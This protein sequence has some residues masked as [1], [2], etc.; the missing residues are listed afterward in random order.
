MKRIFAIVLMGLF[1]TVGFA[2][3]GVTWETQQPV[4]NV[5]SI[6]ILPNAGQAYLNNLRRTWVSAMEEAKKLELISDY[7]ILASVSD[8]S[9]GFNLLLIIQYPNLAALDA[10]SAIRAK[11]MQLD[12]RMEEKISTEESQE[13]SLNV[14]PELRKIENQQLMRELKFK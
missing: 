12:Q 6:R 2:Q 4:W 1:F 11:W 3:E 9:P 5:T 13:I 8:N 7:K 10:T 14:Y